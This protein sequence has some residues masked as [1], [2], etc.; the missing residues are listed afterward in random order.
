M[1]I[2]A[3]QDFISR[4]SQIR[5]K[6]VWPFTK[7]LLQFLAPRM[8]LTCSCFRCIQYQRIKI[9]YICLKHLYCKL[10][11]D[12]HVLSGLLTFEAFF[13]YYMSPKK[14]L[15][16]TAGLKNKISLRGLGSITSIQKRAFFSSLSRHIIMKTISKC[17]VK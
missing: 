5:L 11:K 6:K 2:R 3:L 12:C 8:F 14:V 1:Q 16:F 4:N 7:K 17:C 15:L 10:S 9:G 13:F